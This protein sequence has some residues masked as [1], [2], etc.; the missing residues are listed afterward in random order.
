MPAYVINVDLLCLICINPTKIENIYF[1]LTFSRFIYLNLDLK[2]VRT[3]YIYCR[4][5]SSVIFKLRQRSIVDALRRLPSA[6]ERYLIPFFRIAISLTIFLPFAIS[7]C[8]VML[9]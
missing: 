8:Y 2:T 4:I 1:K 3:V 5:T 7:I 6:L 9:I